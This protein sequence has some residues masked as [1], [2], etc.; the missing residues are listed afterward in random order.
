MRDCSA[1]CT[2]EKIHVNLAR[3]LLSASISD[4]VEGV[5]IEKIIS[6]V[7]S[8]SLKTYFLRF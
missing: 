7:Y 1:E 4:Q 6:Q 5:F 2:S 3:L 8:G